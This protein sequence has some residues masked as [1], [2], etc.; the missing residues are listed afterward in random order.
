[1]TT[2]TA[3]LETYPKP[4]SLDHRKLA[5]TIDALIE[6]AQTCAFCADACLGEDMVADLITC[7]AM[8]LDC[9]DLCGAA[10]RM[11]SR[12]VGPQPRE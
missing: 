8:N 10:V 11:L 9:A 7:V 4:I 5:A 3:M 12:R 1:M 2:T 6:C